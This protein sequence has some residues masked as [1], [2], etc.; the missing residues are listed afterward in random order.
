[1]AIATNEDDFLRDANLHGG[2]LRGRPMG[3]SAQWNAGTR[4]QRVNIA[5]KVGMSI[6]GC[7]LK[8]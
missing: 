8:E 4:V 5:E 2:S 3:R 6:R 7:R 1:M